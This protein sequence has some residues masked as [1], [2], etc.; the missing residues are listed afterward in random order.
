MGDDIQERRERAFESCK[1][2]ARHWMEAEVVP[3]LQ[4]SDKELAW[5]YLPFLL[6]GDPEQPCEVSVVA[7]KPKK[8][9]SRTRVLEGAPEGTSASAEACIEHAIMRAADGDRGHDLALEWAGAAYLETG[10]EPPRPLARWIAERLANPPLS[11]LGRK[12]TAW[13]DRRIGWLVGFLDHNL[14][15]EVKKYNL[16]PKNRLPIKR[17]LE[18]WRDHCI[19]DAV[20]EACNDIPALNS[21]TYETVVRSRRRFRNELRPRPDLYAGHGFD[22]QYAEA[23]GRETAARVAARFRGEN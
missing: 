4:A 9:I 7:A 17:S 19:C 16:P 22:P 23:I 2:Y 18:A 10:R 8:G 11:R 14:K 13:R 6:E 20:A 3:G 5:A 12:P 21:V 1:K 15:S